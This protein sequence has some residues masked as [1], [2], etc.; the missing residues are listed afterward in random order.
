MHCVGNE[1]CDSQLLGY[2]A[3]DWFLNLVYW[4]CSLYLVVQFASKSCEGVHAHVFSARNLRDFE[5]LEIP[6]EILDDFQ[7][8]IHPII[9]DVVVTNVLA[10]HELGIAVC[11]DSL[12]F[13]CFSETELRDERLILGFVV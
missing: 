7:V 5:E 9:P 3:D 8:S 13:D 12:S 6:C 2:L 4:D 1:S 11:A 10:Y